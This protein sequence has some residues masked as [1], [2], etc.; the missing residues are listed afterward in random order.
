[1]RLRAIATH[2]VF[3]VGVGDTI[4]EAALRMARYDIRHLPVVDGRTPVGMVSDRDVL[5][6][7]DWP[8]RD[9]D[10]H[11]WQQVIDQGNTMVVEQIMSKPALSLALDDEVE[12]GARLMLNK[13][14]SAVPLVGSHTFLPYPPLTRLSRHAV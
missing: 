2:E 11:A 5:L 6:Q 9:E 13:K 12:K 4:A 7:L 14:V 8:G 10:L 3:T 1:M